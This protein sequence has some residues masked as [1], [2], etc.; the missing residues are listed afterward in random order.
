M[1]RGGPD[2]RV[3]NK[4]GTEEVDRRGQKN[5]GDPGEL[6]TDDWLLAERR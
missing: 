5:D 1:A 6:A 4:F 3:A 2:H